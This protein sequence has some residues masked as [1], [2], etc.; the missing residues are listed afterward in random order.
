MSLYHLDRH[1]WNDH[2]ARL[3]PLRHPA[4]L[5]ERR[6]T[7]D[8][9]WLSPR[10]EAAARSLASWRQT[11]ELVVED[12]LELPHEVPIVAEGPG[13]LPSLVWPL[14]SHR[15]QGI[16]LIADGSLYDLTSRRLEDFRRR[17]TDPE[18]A[19]C[20]K[21]RHDA[22][23]ARVAEAEAVQ[24]GLPYL[25]ATSEIAAALVADQVAE[26]FASLESAPAEPTLG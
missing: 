24:L 1:H 11:F 10:G 15:L 12:L 8:E 22:E 18:R 20:A 2:A 16:W 6:L 5:E 25:R 7:F 19:L 4:A 21:R 13:A 9:I 3:D 14:L 23:I 26:Q 17:S